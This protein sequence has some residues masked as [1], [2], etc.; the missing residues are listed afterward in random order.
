MGV[1]CE[2]ITDCRRCESHCKEEC[3]CAAVRQWG[4]RK[5]EERGG[6]EWSNAADQGMGPMGQVNSRA[7]W[8]GV[9]A[10]Y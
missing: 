2:R 6:K 4:R 10:H 5:H 9:D 7:R 3:F 1:G 8:G